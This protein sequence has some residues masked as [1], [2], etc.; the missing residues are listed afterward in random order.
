MFEDLLATWQE[1]GAM[2]ADVQE[3][4]AD[5]HPD[6]VMLML[7]NC[8]FKA[9]ELTEQIKLRREHVLGLRAY[10]KINPSGTDAEMPPV[11]QLPVTGDG[12][13]IS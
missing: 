11:R 3:N 12:P 8:Q 4:Y 2:L 10:W 7:D 13:D 1:L 6:D 5:T 9:M